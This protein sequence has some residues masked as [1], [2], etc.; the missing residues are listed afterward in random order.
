MDVG[1]STRVALAQRDK[2][3]SWLASEVGMSRQALSYIRRRESAS[4]ATIKKIADALDMKVS[5][6]IALGETEHEV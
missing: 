1:R 4:G 2:T 6:F 3:F 5:E